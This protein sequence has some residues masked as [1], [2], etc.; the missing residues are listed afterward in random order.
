M[1][2]GLY[3]MDALTTSRNCFGKRSFKVSAQD[4]HLPS[5]YKMNSIAPLAFGVSVVNDDMDFQ[6]RDVQNPFRKIDG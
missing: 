6:N 4:F 3:Y 5:V 2:D 1:R